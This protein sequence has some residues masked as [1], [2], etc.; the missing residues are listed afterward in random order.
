MLTFWILF[1]VFVAAMLILDLGVFH[2]GS[3]EMS[4]KKAVLGSLFWIS[5]AIAFAGIVYFWQGH[6]KALEF[7]AGYLIE[8]SL[9]VD[10]LFVFLVLFNYFK[11]PQRY[12]YNVLFWGIIGALV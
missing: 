1:N 6:Q 12:Q 2:R 9:S 8:H 5:L 7:G 3:N 4:F 11:V 10:N